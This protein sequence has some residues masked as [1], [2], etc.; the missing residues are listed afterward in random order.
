MNEIQKR[1]FVASD[2]MLMDYYDRSPSDG[3]SAQYLQTQKPN[4]TFIQNG[5]VVACGG[6]N[7]FYRGCAEAWVFLSKKPAMSVVM[8]VKHQFLEWIEEYHLRRVQSPTLARWEAGCR[9][10]KFLGMEYEGYLRKSSIDGEDQVL[11]A[12]VN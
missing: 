7:I 5:K 9:F 12:R 10:L 1:S 3:E 11:Y 6:F 4:M 8:G 2:L